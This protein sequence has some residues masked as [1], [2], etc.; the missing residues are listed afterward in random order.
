LNLFPPKVSPP[1]V[2]ALRE[3]CWLQYSSGD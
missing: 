1:C 3:L 2:A